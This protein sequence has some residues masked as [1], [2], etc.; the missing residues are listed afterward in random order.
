MP[1]GQGVWMSVTTPTTAAARAD[2]RDPERPGLPA[3][4]IQDLG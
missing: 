4:V 2:H 1:L 3:S